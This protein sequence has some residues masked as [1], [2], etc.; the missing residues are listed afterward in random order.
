MPTVEITEDAS[1]VAGWSFE[2]I[3]GALVYLQVSL[4]SLLS[5][6]YCGEG[7]GEWEGVFSR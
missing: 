1:L 2:N 7:V 6:V 3:F 5:S 4:E